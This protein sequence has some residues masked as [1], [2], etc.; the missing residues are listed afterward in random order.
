MICK[1]CP[2]RKEIDAVEVMGG[3][4]EWVCNKRHSECEDVV[5]L[6]RMVIW[7][8]YNLLEDDDESD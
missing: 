8:L 1:N 7:T 5:C 4:P 2:D 3:A 6:L